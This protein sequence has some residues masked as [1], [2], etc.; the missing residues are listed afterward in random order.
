M[1]VTALAA[2]AHARDGQQS[3]TGNRH[4]TQRILHAPQA[5]RSGPLPSQLS[6]A[7]VA[8]LKRAGKTPAAIL[9]IALLGLVLDSQPRDLTRSHAVEAAFEG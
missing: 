4:Y 6:S 1:K 3:F 5:A 8:R 9:A 7:G 2:A